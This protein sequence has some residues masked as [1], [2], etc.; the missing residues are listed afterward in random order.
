M[1]SLFIWNMTLN[2]L[3]H[4]KHLHM[5]L[6]QLNYLNHRPKTKWNT[7]FLATRTLQERST[8]SSQ[9]NTWL[10]KN[11]ASSSA[12]RQ[13]PSNFRYEF[14]IQECKLLN[15]RCLNT[16]KLQAGDGIKLLRSYYCYYYCYLE[17]EYN[18]TYLPSNNDRPVC[19]YTTC[20]VGAP[21]TYRV[22]VPNIW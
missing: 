14:Q 2:Q 15:G 10:K 17:Q 22:G 21:L 6:K 12:P 16:I 20:K 13:W 18:L 5:K 9:R 1:S 4:L 8:Y 19:P 11:V 7:Y 3:H